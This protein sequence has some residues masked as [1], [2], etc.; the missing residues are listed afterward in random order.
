MTFGFRL[1]AWGTL[2]FFLLVPI[3]VLIDSGA[4]IQNWNDQSAN[5]T[6]LV[7][8]YQIADRVCLS[9]AG[10]PCGR[11]DVLVSYKIDE[12]SYNTSIPVFDRPFT[13]HQYLEDHYPIGGSVTIYYNIRKPTDAKFELKS[14]QAAIRGAIVFSVGA[15]FFVLTAILVESILYCRKIRSSL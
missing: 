4:R 11:G 7:D 9:A 1:I 3:P 8:G 14:P 13:L 5:T 2:V 15:G 6:A 10:W 12:T